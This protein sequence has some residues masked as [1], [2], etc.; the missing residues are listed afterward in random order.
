M[1]TTRIP[2]HVPV[3]RAHL[4]PEYKESHI[5]RGGGRIL[6]NTGKCFFRLSAT[7]KCC[8]YIPR[9]AGLS[10]RKRV[11]RTAG[12]LCAAVRSPDILRGPQ[13]PC[14]TRPPWDTSSS[15]AGVS[16][17]PLRLQHSVSEAHKNGSLFPSPPRTCWE[18]PRNLHFKGISEKGVRHFNTS[19][20]LDVVTQNSE[21]PKAI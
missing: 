9:A 4:I 11:V 5:K 2:L 18:V 19:M 21:K 1:K 16:P 13:L 6:N 15:E 7:W 12:T 10:G 20:F 3:V 8:L 14:C 17:S